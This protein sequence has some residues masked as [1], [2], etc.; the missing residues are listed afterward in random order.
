MLAWWQNESCH[1]MKGMRETVGKWYAEW[2]PPKRLY[3]NFVWWK[4]CICMCHVSSLDVAIGCCKK[5][6]WLMKLCKC[7]SQ[8]GCRWASCKF[9]HVLLLRI[10]R[11]SKETFQLPNRATQKK[12]K[13]KKEDCPTGRLNNLELDSLHIWFNGLKLIQS[14]YATVFSSLLFIVCGI[15]VRSCHTHKI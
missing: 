10:C 5:K 8:S 15:H 14:W 11:Q 6:K 7:L 13:R 12:R 9:D 2:L 4:W 1:K 3:F